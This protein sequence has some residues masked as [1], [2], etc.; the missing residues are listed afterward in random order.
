MELSF[1]YSSFAR[2]WLHIA[3][4]W[5]SLIFKVVGMSSDAILFCDKTRNSLHFDQTN[6]VQ[7]A[8]DDN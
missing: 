1:R 8:F 3:Q 6:Q 2:S 7:N 4:I 5:E